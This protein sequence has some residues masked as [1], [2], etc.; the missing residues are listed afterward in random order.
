MQTKPRAFGGFWFDTQQKNAKHG[1]AVAPRSSVSGCTNPFYSI[2]HYHHLG[3][4]K[5]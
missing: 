3:K 5:Q 2:H 1:M 4:A